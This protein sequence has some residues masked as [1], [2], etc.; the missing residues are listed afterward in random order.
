[1]A[2]LDTIIE[3]Q[4]QRI[5]DADIIKKL[6]DEGI[7]PQEI[8]DALNQAKIKTAVSGSPINQEFEEMEQSIMNAPTFEQA[9]PTPKQ[10][11]TKSSSPSEPQYSQPEV[12]QE[13]QYGYYPETNQPYSEQYAYPGS[14]DTSTITEISEQVV[15]EKIQEFEAKTG[16]LVSFKNEIQDKIKDLNERLKRIENSIQVLQNSIIKKI[17]EFDETSSLIHQDLENV[18]NTMSKMM[19]PLIDNYRELKKI[20]E[21]K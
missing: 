11:Q 14:L 16:D 15:A 20:T 17:G 6:R 5:P 1:M 10:S 9:P 12:S 18:H 13:Q 3:M 8:N 4:N 19:N 7:S 2:L 21:K